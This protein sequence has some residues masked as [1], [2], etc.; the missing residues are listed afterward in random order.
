MI[1]VYVE[2]KTID[3]TWFKLLSEIYS[4]GRI[5][6]IDSGSFAGSKRLEFD[7][8]SGV[9]QYPTIRPLAPI[10]P[11]G[12]PP[13]TTDADIE[14]YFVNYLMNS[15]LEKGEH[16][17]Y[18]TWITGGS[19]KVPF[20]KMANDKEG[21]RQGGIWVIVPNQIQW[22]IDHYKKKGFG[23]NHCCI[24]IGY[25][26]SSYAYDIPYKNETD[27][28]TSPCLQSIDTKIIRENGLHYLHFSV[29]FR[30]W[31]L[32]GAFPGNMGGITLLME[33]M[34]NELGIEVGSLAFSSLKLH[35]YSH[36]L[37]VL[38]ARLGK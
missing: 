8:V 4:R 11:E 22:C 3:S 24:K 14:D 34:A 9:I 7:Y 18:A 37:E 6:K 26:E 2:E 30:S 38:K 12:L 36:S 5:N 10:M 19:Y 27:R 25:P 1:S 13:V 31:D 32:Y 15:K 23:N 33:Y 28:G 29:Y 35:C 16:Y 21:E 17:K 20:M